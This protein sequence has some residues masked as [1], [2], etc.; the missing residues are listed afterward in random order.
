MPCTHPW[1][2][3]ERMV[4]GMATQTFR[5][6]Q[7]KATSVDPTR[8]VSNGGSFTRLLGKG[9]H[10]TLL[11][12]KIDGAI[13]QHIV[14]NAKSGAD[15]VGLAL[16]QALN[17][18]M[19]P[20]E[21]PEVVPYTKSVVKVLAAPETGG[22]NNQALTD[23]LVLAESI[24]EMIPDDSWVALSLRPPTSRESKQHLT[25]LAHRLGQGPSP[26]HYANRIDKVIT[27]VTVGALHEHDAM[28]FAQYFMANLPG[29]DLHTVAR[30]ASRK[31]Q[32]RWGLP[33]AAV[34]GAVTFIGL[35]M[36]PAEVL[37]GAPD[38]VDTVRVPGGIAA[39]VAAVA[40][41]FGLSPMAPNEY[42]SFMKQ[43][44][45][46]F[47]APPARGG[48]PRK[49]SEARTKSVPQKLSDGSTTYTTVHVPAHAGDYPLHQTAFMM[50]PS[51]FAV[52][53]SPHAS[54]T[55]GESVEKER[56]LPPALTEARGPRVGTH[57]SGAPVFLDASSIMHGT[58]IFGTPGAGKSVLTRALFA[59]SCLEKR[60]P[61]RRPGTPGERNTLIAFESK[62]RGGADMYTRW[63]KATGVPVT[64]IDLLNPN[65][66]SI[67][68]FD[69]AKGPVNA[70][71]SFVSAMTYAWGED[72]IGA[73]SGPVL[74]Q[75]FV[76]AQAVDAEVVRIHNQAPDV[77][78][79]DEGKSPVYYAWRLMGGRNLGDAKTLFDALVQRNSDVDGTNPYYRVAV[80]HAGYIFAGTDS[81]RRT[82]TESSKNKLDAL[83]ELEAWW[84]PSRPSKTWSQ[85][86]ADHDTV[87]LNIGPSDQA[88]GFI[89][90]REAPLVSA[91]LMA[92]LQEAI[93]QTCDDWAAQ[94]RWVSV[95]AD[96]L[97]MIA[98]KNGA[99]IEWIRSKGRSFGVRPVFATQYPEQLSDQVRNSL[100]DYSTFV[101]FRQGNR[102]TAGTVA[103]QIT[104][105]SSE[106]SDEDLTLM[107]NYHMV[108]RTQVAGRR[109]DAVLV[110]NDFFEDKM[111]EF[112]HHQGYAEAPSQQP[113]Q[114]RPLQMGRPE[115]QLEERN[116]QL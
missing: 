99:V 108:V 38:L 16:A 57:A 24:N 95:F 82:L 72:A 52:M 85:L 6:I 92:T 7:R 97:S 63:G 66:P 96:E 79:L 61:S 20:D 47:P 58:S 111:D 67:N 81:Q 25:W 39:A 71:R 29:F 113:Q 86:L 73:R 34:I 50:D 1:G 65:T 37:A 64:L 101:S 41:G 4:L 62:G 51:L 100:M 8:F 48:A 109:Q 15:Q 17:A 28:S 53:V 32:L 45:Q 103:Y 104:T 116:V 68:F 18:H 83:V 115:G 98:G 33:A 110:A 59:W 70:A 30:P 46:G 55:T 105:S 22:R 87:V 12:T 94:N 27:T 77:I 90:D 93:V 44:A 91:M 21:M 88:E 60:S 5:F 76:A 13:S 23:L 36:L 19:E 56:V 102:T 69:Q 31:S 40:G 3:A 106:W 78:P 107:P 54:T 75:M 89:T 43:L 49:P 84:N 112:A 26:T 114:V 14:V 74:I 9:D 35:P 11:V 42:D 2:H 10:A 80:E